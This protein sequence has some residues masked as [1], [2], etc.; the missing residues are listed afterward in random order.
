MSRMSRSVLIC[1][2]R[3]IRGQK[4]FSAL[5]GIIE[6]QRRFAFRASVTLG[7]GRSPRQVKVADVEV[8]DLSGFCSARITAT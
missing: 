2:I 3:E 7:R 5:P 1:E 6:E 4:L 8:V